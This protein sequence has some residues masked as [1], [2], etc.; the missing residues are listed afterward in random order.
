MAEKISNY[1]RVYYHNSG[2]YSP[3]MNKKYLINE[4]NASLLFTG[5]EQ[6]SITII[7]IEMSDSEWIDR[8]D[9]LRHYGNGQKEN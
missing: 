4:I 9:E 6:L 1:Y 8:P 2:V 7:P 5:L 3:V